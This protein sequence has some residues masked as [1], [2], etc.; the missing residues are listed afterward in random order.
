MTQSSATITTANREIILADHVPG[1]RQGRWTYNHYAAL[2]PGEKHYEIIDGVLYMTPSS[3]SE[4]H[5]KALVRFAYYL[6]NYIELAGLGRVYTL[7]FDVE[8]TPHIIIQPDVLVLLNESSYKI[9]HSHIIGAPDLIIEIASPATAS[10]DRNIKYAAYARAG[11]KE[12]W[13][14]DPHA[15]SVES[16]ILE[17]EIYHSTGRFG[18]KDKLRSRIVPNF[19]VQV[20][21][22]FS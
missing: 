19:P 11:V 20:Q 6:F 5:Q 2:P 3:P 22:L 16:L 14:A 15:H 13:I 21:Q 1:P 7:P 10:Y 18:G 17:Q 4:W 12:Y 8:L 9:A